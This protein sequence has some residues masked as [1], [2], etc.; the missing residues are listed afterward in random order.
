MNCR[1]ALALC[2][3]LVLIGCAAGESVKKDEPMPL[4]LNWIDLHGDFVLPT[5]VYVQLRK[6]SSLILRHLLFHWSP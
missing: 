4:G 3:S 5:N 2:T 6:L 1:C